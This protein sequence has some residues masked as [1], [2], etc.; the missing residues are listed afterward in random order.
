MFP[1]CACIVPANSLIILCIAWDKSR[2]IGEKHGQAHGRKNQSITRPGKY[3]DGG[4]L[5][6]RV[7]P[8]GSKQWVQ[9]LTVH[10][11]R[12]DIG[13]GPWPVRSLEGARRK[14]LENRLLVLDGGDPLAGKHRAK[15]PTFKEAAKKAHKANRAR[16]R[17]DKHSRNWMASLENY[18]F[19]TLGNTPVD[20]IAGQDVL[21]ILGPIWSTQTDTARRVRQR[22]RTVLGWALA[23]GYVTSNAA[24][25]GIDGALPVISTA[26]KTSG[27]CPIR[28]SLLHSKQSRLPGRPCRQSGPCGSWC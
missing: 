24:G 9:R 1:F 8:G 15:V 11:Q 20:R 19:P 22:I 12:H 14:A 13:L 5:Y 3:A 7:A 17:A 10:G 26:P 2:D 16:W 27:H 28:R 23:H 25:D 4:T 21:R 6:L 18:A